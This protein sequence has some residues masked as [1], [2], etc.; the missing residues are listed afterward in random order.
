MYLELKLSIGKVRAKKATT[1]NANYGLFWQVGVK[2]NKLRVVETSIEILQKG[3]SLCVYASNWL[4]FFFFS[5]FLPCISCSF[6]QLD[7]ASYGHFLNT[8]PVVSTPTAKL[9]QKENCMQSET[10]V[11][12][13]PHCCSS[14]IKHLI[15][16]QIVKKS[17]KKD[18]KWMLLF[19]MMQII[20][21]LLHLCQWLS[22]PPSDVISFFTLLSVWIRKLRNCD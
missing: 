3:F 13:H 19:W 18:L 1:E 10:A 15:F 7:I 5:F 22:K 8:I 17:R 16:I 2:K 14:S 4:V 20:L 9:R 11:P 6:P 12:S 21:A